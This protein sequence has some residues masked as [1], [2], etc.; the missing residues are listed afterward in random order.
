MVHLESSNG[1][2]LH[3]PSLPPTVW[4]SIVPAGGLL[5]LMEEGVALFICLG[6]TCLLRDTVQQWGGAGRKVALGTEKV[7]E[8][9]NQGPIRKLPFC[10]EHW[11]ISSR[12]C[13]HFCAPT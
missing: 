3:Q 8:G 9:D 7:L 10:R 11:V 1:F 4:L 2:H 5:T 6:E 12:D 13:E